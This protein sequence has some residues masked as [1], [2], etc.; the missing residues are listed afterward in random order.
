MVIALD[1]SD[2]SSDPFTFAEVYFLLLTMRRDIS[3]FRRAQ[4]RV[5]FCG[6]KMRPVRGL[7]CGHPEP[8]ALVVCGVY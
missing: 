4:H 3:D 5:W 6:D 7:L 2:D 1:R 8:I